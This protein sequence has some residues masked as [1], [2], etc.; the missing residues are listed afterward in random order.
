MCTEWLKFLDSFSRLGKRAVRLERIRALLNALGDPQKKLRFIHVTG[1]NGKGSIC[2]MLSE[3]F[4]RS[5][6][7]VGLFT[8]PYITEYNDRIRINGENIHDSELLKLLPL[9]REAAEKSGYMSDFSQFEIT[10]AAAFCHFKE[11]GCD[12]VILEAG[13]GGLLD[14]TNIIDDNICSV[15]GSVGLD[16]TAVLGNTIEQIAY[17][18][19]GIIKHSCPCI[20][21]PCNDERVVRIFKEQAADK[22]SELIIPDISKANV[23]EGGFYF[24]GIKAY[25]GEYRTAMPG[26]HQIKN[27]LAV[28]YACFAASGEF[29][30]APKALKDGIGAAFIPG[31]AQIISQKPLVILDGGHNPDAAK[32]LADVLS[33][34]GGRF[35]AVIGMSDDKAIAQYISTIS[36]YVDKF[37]CIDDFSDRALEKS[38]L[39]KTVTDQGGRAM[40]A[41]TLASALSMTKST[42]RTVICG[43]L[44]LV[45]AVLETYTHKKT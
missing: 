14:S 18:K 1:T 17:Q 2:E 32:A 5:G 40:T 15:I 37:I 33:F 20:L 38:K 10:Q 43:S 35:T 16:H 39:A 27:A 29:D 19:A 41:K 25:E 42:N 8:S 23:T 12:I 31:R 34:H 45:S 13:L 44:F 28:I 30:I 26:A 21:S 24:D 7:R 4:I 9:V 3:V 36:P 11:Q 6:Y 22:G